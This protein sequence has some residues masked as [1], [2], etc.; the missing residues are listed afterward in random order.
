MSLPPVNLISTIDELKS[1][2]DEKVRQLSGDFLNHNSQIIKYKRSD[3]C[4]LPI[5]HFILRTSKC[6][7]VAAV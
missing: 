4:L 5:S 1:L 2:N 6:A 7:Y 3:G